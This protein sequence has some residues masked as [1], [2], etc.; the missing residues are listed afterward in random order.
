[1]KQYFKVLFYI[2]IEKPPI[3]KPT[4]ISAASSVAVPLQDNEIKPPEGIQFCE[5]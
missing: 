5:D 4:I 2:Q 1:M 3:I